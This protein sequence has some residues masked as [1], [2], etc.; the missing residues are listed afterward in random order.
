M[1]KL[2]I[3]FL[4]LH[5]ILIFTDEAGSSSDNNSTTEVAKSSVQSDQSPAKTASSSDTSLG[6][7]S[8]AH[9]TFTHHES[10]KNNESVHD[11]LN[12][13]Q[14]H[15]PRAPIYA[16][17]E[18]IQKTQATERVKGNNS[19]AENL[20]KAEKVVN[21]CSCKSTSRKYKHAQAVI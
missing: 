6:K 2:F 15:S 11:L 21:D 4:M 16:S 1:K 5:S 13:Y 18:H 20:K 17:Q 7:A 9:T 14:R 10:H 12:E 3:I 19:R 8:F